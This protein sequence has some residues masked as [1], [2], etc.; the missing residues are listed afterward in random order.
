MDHLNRLAPFLVHISLM[1]WQSLLDTL[2]FVPDHPFVS[3]IVAGILIAISR[4]RSK[5]GWRSVMKHIV[6]DRRRVTKR[7]LAAALVLYL[8][9]FFFL[10]PKRLYEEQLAIANSVPRLEA[11]LEAKRHALSTTDPAFH[12][13]HDVVRMF[14]SYRR[15][16]GYDA[17]C[18]ILFTATTKEG[19]EL[20]G[21]VMP[22]AVLGSN[23]SNG[24]LQNIGVRS[25]E[26]GKVESSGEIS[27]VVNL[28]APPEAKGVDQLVSN[29][30]SYIQVRR[31]YSL[32]RPADDNVMWLQF[33]PGVKWN[34]QLH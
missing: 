26:V 29:L 30:G 28:H 32:P 16:I 31:S 6:A 18:R 25:E 11:E 19:K 7:A 8:V 21:I 23:C 13:M 12:N 17:S 33:G 10:T 15:A 4:A 34:S 14:M 22:L 1:L 20:I 24:D 5:Q 9:H 27:G 2:A 3:I